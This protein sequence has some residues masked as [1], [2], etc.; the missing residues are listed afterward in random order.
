MLE[1]EEATPKNGHVGQEQSKPD[2][3]G[4]KYESLV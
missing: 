4:G 3:H 2:G 1:I